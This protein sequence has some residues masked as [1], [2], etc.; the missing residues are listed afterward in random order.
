MLALQSAG[1]GDKPWGFNITGM[2]MEDWKALQ[3]NAKESRAIMG[4]YP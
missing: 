3:S 4:D 2:S 1:E